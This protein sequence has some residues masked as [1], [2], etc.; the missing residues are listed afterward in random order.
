MSL[1]ELLISIHW[2]YSLIHRCSYCLLKATESLLYPAAWKVLALALITLECFQTSALEKNILIKQ[3]D[4]SGLSYQPNIYLTAK[5]NVN[6]LLHT[7]C[8]RE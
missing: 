5:K 1:Y 4:V 8:Y 7:V 2:K 3:K 6:P